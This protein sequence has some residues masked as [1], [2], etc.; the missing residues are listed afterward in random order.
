MKRSKKIVRI[1][2]YGVGVNLVLTAGKMAVGLV[3]NS[4]SIVLDAVNNLTDVLSSVVT[5][6]G[7]KLSEKKPD[8]NH[9]FGHGRIEY[10]T[11]IVVALIV[12]VAGVTAFLEAIE[13]IV[14]PE[15]AEYSPTSLVV[16]FVAVIVKFCFG[17]YVRKQGKM[18]N[19]G[20][21][22]ASGVDAL[23][24]AALSLAVFVG[25]VVSVVWGVSLEGY[26]GVV[27]AVFIIRTA[28][29]IMRQ[30]LNDVLGVR[31]DKSVVKKL[32][33][34]IQKYPEVL[35][36]YDMVL[37][38]YGP[39]KI[40]ASVHI[41]VDDEMRA[42]E[43]HLLTRRMEI[44]VYEKMGI[45]MTTGI[46]ASNDEGEFGEMKKFI[47]SVVKEIPT[48]I[49][50]HGFYVD[51]ENKL[52]TFDL[53]FSFDEEEVEEQQKKILQ[54]VKEKYPEYNFSVIIDTDVAG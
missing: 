4:I 12:L 13:K 34:I 44:E 27:I 36:V 17:R 32:E 43:I 46:Y 20:S 49:Q 25:A 26:L 8:K 3:A 47:E 14:Q 38:N 31:A 48:V 39:N 9:P 5:I 15:V 30:G 41:Q 11:A 16:V 50:M 54:K 33:K 53:I 42:R 29:E 6:V 37:H 51:A 7:T 35:G 23:S 1:S 19:S 45:I 18:L 40:V 22:V 24:D 52:V 28:I 10:I 2:L 21:L